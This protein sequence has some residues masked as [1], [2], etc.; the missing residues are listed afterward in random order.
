MKLSKEARK[1][2]RQLFQLSFTNGVL[3]GAKVRALTQELT[4]SKPRD[5]FAALKNY[6][7]L[8]RMET[9]RRHAVVESA[10]PMDNKAQEKL[11]AELK[12]KYGS[13][14]TAEYKV[15]PSLLGG[16]RIKLGS[17]V[18]DGS[19]RGRL[20]RLKEELANT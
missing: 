17:D 8:I 2:S 15:N 3:D 4:A 12:K 20:D 18:W 14:I 7:R 10:A 11:V 16:L 1:I 19:V 5:Y 13:D 9:E 6:Q